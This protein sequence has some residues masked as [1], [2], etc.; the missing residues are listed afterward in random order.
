MLTQLLSHGMQDNSVLCTRELPHYWHNSW[1]SQE[2]QKR[3]QAKTNYT[4]AKNIQFRVS[5]AYLKSIPICC[6]TPN[7]A[8]MEVQN[9]RLLESI[10]IVFA[11]LPCARCMHTAIWLSISK[12][13]RSEGLA[14][15]L[16]M[17]LHKLRY[18]M[19]T[20]KIQQC[21]SLGAAARLFISSYIWYMITS[22]CM[23]A[24]T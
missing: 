24:T 23:K 19:N 18:D 21:A 2:I 17:K 14:P 12:L 5:T 7:K 9:S 3:N 11:K 4:E 8:A 15:N 1:R 13:R 22:E 6:E 20:T 10:V 16:Q